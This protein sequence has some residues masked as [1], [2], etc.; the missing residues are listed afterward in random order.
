MTELIAVL[1]DGA[2]PIT[3]FIAWYMGELAQRWTKL[4]RISVYAVVGFI[5]ASSQSGFLP[6]TNSSTTLLA[7]IAFGL[8][9]FECGYRINLHWLRTNPW[10]VVTSVTESMFIFIAVYAVMIWFAQSQ[11]MALLLAALSTASSPA[12]IIRV[13]LEQR[14]SGQVTERALHLSVLNSMLAVLV[15]KMILGLVVFNTSGNVWDAIH[16]SLM[17]LFASAGVGAVLGMMI[18]T[19]LRPTDRT[20]H[21]NTLAFTITVIGLVALTHS[22]KLSPIFAVLIFGIVARHRRVVLTSSQRGFGSLG[23]LVS[24]FL[25]VFIAAKLAWGQVYAGIWLGLFI[26]VVRQLVKAVVISIFAKLSG[27]S[28]HKGWLVGLATAPMSVSIILMLEQ[29]RYRGVDLVAQLSPLIAIALMLEILGPVLS[30]LA[31]R[32]AHEV[33]E[34]HKEV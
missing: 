31:L 30:Q 28:W 34:P 13:I 2:W 20:T 17:V 5:L 11:M 3:I 7:N 16:I 26:L 9:L 14:S 22:L 32:W 12:T 4:P 21:D 6:P 27:I 29:A 18:P 8:L 23:E 1:K 24:I 15:F 25:F 19:L 10:I 33:A